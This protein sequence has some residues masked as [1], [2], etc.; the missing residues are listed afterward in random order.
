MNSYSHTLSEIHKL[1]EELSNIGAGIRYDESLPEAARELASALLSAEASDYLLIYYSQ[2][3]EE[4][5]D[6]EGQPLSASKRAE[7]EMKVDRFTGYG[8]SLRQSVASV[9]PT[10]GGKPFSA[11]SY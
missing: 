6:A 8:D 7:A 10:A 3:L 11:S 9:R 1:A 2:M 4:G 5:V